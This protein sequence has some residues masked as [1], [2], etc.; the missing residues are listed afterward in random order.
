LPYG[1]TFEIEWYPNSPSMSFTHSQR[2][3]KI[4]LAEA[5]QI[6][7]LDSM[8]HLLLSEQA[9][10]QYLALQTTITELQLNDGN[11]RWLHI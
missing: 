3:K 10:C 4:T 11:D 6:M 1:K 2:E 9:Y 7:P 5:M 8:F